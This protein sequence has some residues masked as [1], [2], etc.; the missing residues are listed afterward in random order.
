[1]TI[2]EIKAD[3]QHEVELLE[4]YYNDQVEHED[5]IKLYDEIINSWGFKD[6]EF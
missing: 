5:Q 1:M 3:L 4:A 6:N 2:K